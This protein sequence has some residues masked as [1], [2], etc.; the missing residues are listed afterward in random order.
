MSSG[1]PNSEHASLPHSQLSS[2]P[3]SRVPGW[4]QVAQTGFDA[5]AI[6]QGGGSRRGVVKD[7]P[8]RSQ[9]DGPSNDR[10]L[11]HLDTLA[12]PAPASCYSPSRPPTVERVRRFAC[13]AGRIALLVTVA[14]VAVADGAAAVKRPPRVVSAALED[15]DGNFRADAL[16]LT[17]SQKVRHA[18]DRDGHYPF[19]VSGYRIRSVGAASGRVLVRPVPPVALRRKAGAHQTHVSRLIRIEMLASHSSLALRLRDEGRSITLHDERR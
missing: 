6:V 15:V 1:W 12:P 9:L 16:R 3:R 10:S 18:V 11:V 2:T 7:A 19:S 17:Y 14:V 13:H 5:E 4:P 8:T